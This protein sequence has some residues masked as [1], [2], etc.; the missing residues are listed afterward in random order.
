MNRASRTD[1]RAVRARSHR[2][3]LR[4]LGPWAKGLYTREEWAAL[5][6]ASPGRIER[7]FWKSTMAAPRGPA[8]T[9]QKE[10]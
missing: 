10:E 9:P 8:A 4:S 7:V 3:L 6:S 1:W 5:M 2:R